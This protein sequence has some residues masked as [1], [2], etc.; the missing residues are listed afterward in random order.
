[1]LPSRLFFNLKIAFA[2][3][4]SSSFVSP[5]ASSPTPTHA[6]QSWQPDPKSHLR[7]VSQSLGKALFCVCLFLDSVTGSFVPSKR[8]NAQACQVTSLSGLVAPLSSQGAHHFL[9]PEN[10]GFCH[11]CA[12]MAWRQ[13]ERVRQMTWLLSLWLYPFQREGDLVLLY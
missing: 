2:C 12:S 7:T 1:L 13:N 10:G 8:A 6:R 5:P 3:E 9:F 11:P 4:G